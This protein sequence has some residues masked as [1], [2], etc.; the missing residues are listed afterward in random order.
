MAALLC[1]YKVRLRERLWNVIKLEK[2]YF[3]SFSRYS[4]QATEENTEES[5]SFPGRSIDFP[6]SSLSF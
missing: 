2:Q 4:G 5:D 3:I 6:L 1:A